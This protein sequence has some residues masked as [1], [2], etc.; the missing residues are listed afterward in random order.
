MNNQ[1]SVKRSIKNHKIKILSGQQP[2][3]KLI[4]F[5]GYIFPISA[6]ERIEDHIKPLYDDQASKE[7]GWTFA[8]ALKNGD[9][10]LWEPVKKDYENAEATMMLHQQSPE[11]VESLRI[12]TIEI[13]WG[14]RAMIKKPEDIICQQQLIANNEQ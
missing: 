12:A 11:Y 1:T 13:V 8:I 4:Q 9:I 3:L 6:I 5:G 2:S 10:L 7:I 14:R